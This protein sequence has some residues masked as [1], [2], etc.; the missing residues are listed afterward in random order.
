MKVRK[1]SL[2]RS[3]VRPREIASQPSDTV[4]SGPGPGKSGSMVVTAATVQQAPSA[5]FTD[6]RAGEAT[7]CRDAQGQERPA[8]GRSQRES[9]A[10]SRT[11]A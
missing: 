8:A 5:G 9:S 6:G 2:Q 7:R 3:G 4:G 11:R 1:E 10:L